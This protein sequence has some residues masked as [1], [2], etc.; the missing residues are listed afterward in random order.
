MFL[1]VAIVAPATTEG[2]R[3][4][5]RVVLGRRKA[6]HKPRERIATR[7]DNCRA[8]SLG[9]K[10][11]VEGPGLHV[12]RCVVRL[13]VGDLRLR[14]AVIVALHLIAAPLLEHS[15]LAFGLHAL[16]GQRLAGW[17]K[18]GKPLT[19]AY[20]LAAVGVDGPKEP[21]LG[22]SVEAVDKL[23]AVVCERRTRVG[24]VRPVLDPS[25]TM[26]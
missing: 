3:D 19:L 16:G 13:V 11:P 21:A 18:N 1:V 4:C 5:S 8:C 23:E 9:D 7:R 26:L 12:Q 17:R 20:E 15:G 2:A 14:A 22:Q 6:G 25:F 10:G 24:R